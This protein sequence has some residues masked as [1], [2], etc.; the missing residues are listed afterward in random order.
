[1]RTHSLKLDLHTHS[2]DSPDGGISRAQ[3][4]KLLHNGTLDVIAVTD[5][6]TIRFAQLLQREFG[7]R[8]IVGEEV[9]TTGGDLVGLFLEKA[10][11]K[12]LAPLEAAQR[13]KDQGG[14]VYIPHPFE[15]VRSGLQAN[16]LETIVDLV[17]IVEIY[18]GRALFQN[19]SKQALLWA[20]LHGKAGASSSD[21]HGVRGAGRA[22]TVVG[23]QP[24]AHNI[25]QLLQ[26]PEF[27]LGKPTI[28][29]VLY[30]KYHRI[31]QR[32]RQSRSAA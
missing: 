27:A 25:V 26:R 16:D 18:N 10:I 15:S 3:Y 23:K 24:T 14:I 9:T 8:I 31:R 6:N 28:R 20:R 30:P 11:P 29:S 13:I 21:A 19:K 7:N 2:V 4:Q 22:Y 1:M 32:V 12:G 5:H 17:D